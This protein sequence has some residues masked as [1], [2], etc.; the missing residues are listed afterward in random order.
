[1]V[2]RGMRETND[3]DIVVSAQLFEKC[4]NEG[5][6]QIPWTYPDKIGQK[7]LRRN[8]IELFLDVNCGTFNP[9]LEEL[10]TRTDT[11]E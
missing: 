8:D 2:I 3:I 9:T 7:Y 6:E 4:K 5:W 1:M 11:I 10:I